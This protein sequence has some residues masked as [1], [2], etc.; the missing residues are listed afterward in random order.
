MTL[1]VSL[2]DRM[3]TNQLIVCLALPF[4][5]IIYW[6]YTSYDSR[7]AAATRR[8]NKRFDDF[9]AR[10]G[11]VE[12]ALGVL[13]HVPRKIGV[14]ERRVDKLYQ[15]GPV[16]KGAQAKNEYEAAL[17]DIMGKIG[18]VDAKFRG[19]TIDIN[20]M[21]RNAVVHGQKIDAVESKIDSAISKMDTVLIKADSTI[22]QGGTILNKVDAA[23]LKFDTAATQASIVGTQVETL[24]TQVEILTLK[25]AGIAIANSM[26]PAEDPNSSTLAQILRTMNALTKKVDRMDTKT[27]ASAAHELT[28]VNNKLDGMAKQVATVAQDVDILKAQDKKALASKIDAVEDII[29]QYIARPPKLPGVRLTQKA[30]NK[31]DMAT[32][33]SPSDIQTTK[34]TQTATT[35]LSQSLVTTHECAP[36]APVGAKMKLSPVTTIQEDTP[37]APDKTDAMQLAYY[38]NMNG[39]NETKVRAQEQAAAQLSC[40]IAS[41]KT[42]LEQAMGELNIKSLNIQDLQ[43]QAESHECVA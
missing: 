5:F 40:E 22:V 9:G 18:G 41:L 39:F 15:F 8:L 13:E 17:Q 27:D 38:R 19:L 36:M 1:F 3:S 34:S 31:L 11:R 24:P 6:V 25:V 30:L 26:P 12:R 32:P 14:L 10:F 7:H 20:Q 42:R 37:V 21:T 28:V 35:M 29:Q 33:A 4:L 23:I 2:P 16:N 43:Q